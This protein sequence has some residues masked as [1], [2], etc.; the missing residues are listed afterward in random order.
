MTDRE[1]RRVAEAARLLDD[2]TQ[3]MIPIPPLLDEDNRNQPAA[4][5]PAKDSRLDGDVL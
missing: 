2:M 5:A 1:A 3:Q 4:A